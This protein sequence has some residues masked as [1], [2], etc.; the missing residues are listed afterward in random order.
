M[1]DNSSERT[2]TLDATDVRGSIDS[3]GQAQPAQPPREFP[4][5]P[6]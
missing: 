3:L 5:A 1:R 6:R 2:E 4:E